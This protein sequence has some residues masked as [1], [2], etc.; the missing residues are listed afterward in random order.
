MM[1]PVL[2][3]VTV[4]LY[5]SVN[6]P[7]FDDYDPFPDF[8]DKWISG[9]SFSGRLKLLFQPNNEHRM[10]IGKMITLVYY[11]LTGHLDFT[12]LH[13]AGAC[14]TLGTLTVF[15]NAFRNSRL[16]WW[17]FL[18]VPFLLF[19]LQYHLVFLWAICSLQ[20]QPVIFFVCLS[21]FLLAKRQFAWAVLAALCATYAMSNGIFVWVSG[22]AVLILR[23]DYR[24]LAFWLAAGAVAVG[25]YFYGL[26]AQGNEASIDFFLKNPHLSVLGF[27]AFL[28]GLFD[29]FP[30]KS[31]V[32]RSV[33][34]VLA[35]F[36][37]MVWIVIWLLRQL[38]PFWKKTFSRSAENTFH[39]LGKTAV[40]NSFLLG[41]LV[42][43]LVN[44]LVIGLLRPR[45]GFFVMIVSNYKMYPALFLI[46]AYLSFITSD[47]AGNIRKRGFQLALVI[48]VLIWGIS[49]YTYLPGI[50]E[51]RKYL[52]I[53]GY[54]Q[55]HNAFGL[56][57][58]PFS[59]SAA[60]VDSLMKKMT[61]SHVYNYP[62]EPERIAEQILL[63]QNK[64]GPRNISVFVRDKILYVDEPD[65]RISLARN[66]G[67]YVYLKNEKHLYFFKSNA[68]LYTG[69]NLFRQYDTGSNTTIPFS[70]IEQGTYDLGIIRF[71]NEK[72]G[73]G[74]LRK[75]TIP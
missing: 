17:F 62:D 69:R 68:H 40:L 58:I 46:V 13:I 10:V 5:Y 67:Q 11:R 15:W 45:F 75:I 9:S 71:S 23:S 55:E 21:M 61:A 26:S 34:P 38:N 66:D 43:L 18:P 72:A 42:F 37:T 1:L 49:V 59:Q 20:H 6:V 14:F 12:F 22:A 47:T 64:M 19:Q 30:E 56:G 57:H 31:I 44:A 65:Y 32:T 7:W 41:I 8:L 29:L 35:G 16:K 63:L 48:S 50:A 3:W 28:G 4:L 39:P 52:M 36:V 53:N 60:Y 33:L 27:F 2:L 74:L 24:K 73:G 25:F 54:N 70:F 51:R